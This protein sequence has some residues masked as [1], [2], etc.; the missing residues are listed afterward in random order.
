MSTQNFSRVVSWPYVYTIHNNYRGIQNHMQSSSQTIDH[1][2][3]S[4]KYNILPWNNNTNTLFSKLSSDTKH[5]TNGFSLVWSVIFCTVHLPPATPLM[6]MMSQASFLLKIPRTFLCT[7]E[8]SI[9]ACNYPWELGD[10]GFCNRIWWMVPI[11]NLTRIEFFHIIAG[12]LWN[13]WTDL[14]KYR[15]NYYHCNSCQLLSEDSALWESM[16]YIA[17]IT[18]PFT[19]HD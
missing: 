16:R 17:S 10:G 14:Q 7:L 13:F 9:K 19:R 2:Q 6:A 11:I 1:A 4:S 3:S 5:T 18:F 8:T 15:L 12:I